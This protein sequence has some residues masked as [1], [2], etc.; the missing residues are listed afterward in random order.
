RTQPIRD[1]PGSVSAPQS[2]SAGTRR[3]DT[4]WDAN[5][6]RAFNGANADGMAMQATAGGMAAGTLS[7]LSGARMPQ[8]RSA[9]SR[10]RLIPPPGWPPELAAL[11]TPAREQIA[12]RPATQAARGHPVKTPRGGRR[13]SA[14]VSRSTLP[15]ECNALHQH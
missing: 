12:S 4:F 8:S 11:Q 14:D 5:G 6:A 1:A 9:R 13:P 7:Q 2:L 15:K 10:K 3:P